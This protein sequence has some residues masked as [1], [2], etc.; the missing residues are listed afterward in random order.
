MSKV[1]FGVGS[2]LFLYNGRIFMSTMTKEQ[3]DSKNS[4]KVVYSLSISMVG[5]SKKAF[6]TFLQEIRFV[7]DANLI[8]IKKIDME[9]DERVIGTIR[10]RPIESI[11]MNKQ[12]RTTIV[13]V[14]ETFFNNENWYHKHGVPY[15]MNIILHGLPGTGKSSIIKAI[16]THFNL[17]VNLIDLSEHTNSSLQKAVTAISQ[18]SL[19]AIEDFDSSTPV[20]DRAIVNNLGDSDKENGLP[21]L[22]T[23][24]GIL[25]ALDGIA[26]ANGNI[27]ILTTNVLNNIDSALLRKGRIDHIFEIVA[28]TDKEV[29]EYIDFTNPEYV[30]NP[31]INFEDIK[32]CDLQA[33]L[34][35]HKDDFQSFFNSIPKKNIIHDRIAVNQ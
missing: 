16:A 35:E 31:L 3:N 7:R 34:I 32:G 10:H 21:R 27:I 4:N 17:P 1:I 19:I 25:N 9:G 28:L 30:V 12:L 8:E 6:D 2:N 18:R 11:A 15:K 26:S 13:G 14:I 29:R 20:K 5:R 22:L 23:L 33:L 24:S